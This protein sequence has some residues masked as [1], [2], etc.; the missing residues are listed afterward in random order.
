LQGQ[1]FSSVRDNNN[2]K[3]KVVQHRRSL[4]VRL[5]VGGLACSL[6]PSVCESVAGGAGFDDVAAEDEAVDDGG[7]ESWVGEGLGPAA[8]AIPL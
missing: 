8:E 3:G 6:R 2:P 4:E 1:D 5:P 7:A